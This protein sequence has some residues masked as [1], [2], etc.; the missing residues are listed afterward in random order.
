MKIRYVSIAK[1]IA[2]LAAAIVPLFTRAASG[3]LARTANAPKIFGVSSSDEVQKGD[4][5]IFTNAASE[6]SLLL[7]RAIKADILV[8]GGGGAGANPGA[9]SALQ[10]GAGG[11]GAGGM[12]ETNAYFASGTYYVVV[13]GGGISPEGQGVGGNGEP[14]K[15]LLDGAA[16]YEAFGGGGGG[17]LGAGADGGSGGGGSMA[18]GGLGALGQGFG[19]GKSIYDRAGGGGGGAGSVG[20]VT[21]AVGV[22]GAGGLGKASTITGAKLYYAAGGGGGSRKGESVAFGGNGIGGNGG[23]AVAKATDGWRNSGSGGGGGSLNTKGGNGGSGI[24]VIKIID[25]LPTRPNIA[26]S[27]NYNGENQVVY[28]GSNGVIIKKDGDIVS[29]IAVK[30]A[31]TY[32]YTVILKEGYVWADLTTDAEVAVTVAVNKAVETVTVESIKIEPWQIGQ[33]PNKPVV[34]TT[35]FQVN[36]SDYV[37]KYSPKG[38]N[39]W[40]EE[41]PTEPGVYDVT[42]EFRTDSYTVNERIPFI[43]VTLSAFDEAN[44]AYLDSLGYRSKITITEAIE[45]PLEDVVMPIRIREN[46]PSGFK[47]KY[48]N[49]DGSDIRFVDSEGKLIPHSVHIWNTFGESKILV[50]IPEFKKDAVITMCWGEL[51]NKTPP[52]IEDLG[53]IDEE[54]IKEATHVFTQAEIIPGVCFKN[55]WFVE[56]TITKTQWKYGEEAASVTRGEAVYGDWYYIF[57]SRE[58]ITNTVPTEPGA[59]VFRAQVDGLNAIKD[60]S[61]GYESLVSSEKDVLISGIPA[62]GA[63]GGEGADVTLLGRVL[64]ANDWGYG[65]GAVRGQNYFCTNAVA[66]SYWIHGSEGKFILP[67]LSRSTESRLMSVEPID[68]LCGDTTIWRLS[69]VRI[70][71]LYEKDGTFQNIRNY[72][73]LSPEALPNNELTNSVHLALGNTKDAAIYSPMYTNGIGTI[74]FDAVN[75]I[76]SED[77]SGLGFKIVVEVCT[78]LVNDAVSSSDEEADGEVGADVI[79]ELIW[80]PV[81]MQALKKDGASYFEKPFETERLAL[82]IK[83]GGTAENFYRVYVELNYREPI[84]FRIRRDEVLEDA[85]N[86]KVFI[87]V[88]N[89]VAS[90]PSAR[91]DLESYGKCDENKL[92]KQTL[93]FEGAFDVKFP[94]VNNPFYGRG[95][96]KTEL[97]GEAKNKLLD[98]I[99]SSMIFYRWRYLEQAESEW[100]G[101]VLDQKNGFKAVEPFTL[102]KDMP[103][104]VEY[105]YVSRVNAPYYEYIDYTGLDLNLGGYYSEYVPVVTNRL[106][107]P[108]KFESGGT[109]WFVRLREAKS[110]YEKIN[111]IVT[112]TIEDPD[113]WDDTE[114]KTNSLSMQLVGNGIWRGLY[115]T[116]KANPKGVQYRFEAMN[117]QSDGADEWN[118][119]TNYWAVDKSWDKLPVTDVMR[120]ASSNSWS[121]VTN[122]AVTGYLLF[123]IDD[124]RKSITIVHADYQDFNEWTDANKNGSELFV[125]NSIDDKDKSGVSSTTTRSEV[126]FKGWT[127]MPATNNLWREA[128]AT[129]AGLHYKEY[130]SFSESQTPNGWRAL[131]SMFVYSNYKDEKQ[132]EDNAIARAL[133]MEG[134]GLGSVEL[135]SAHTMPRGI[136]TIS[137][138]ARLAQAVDFNDCAYY[139]GDTGSKM[140]NYTFVVAGAF[141]SNSNKDFRGNASLS[142]FA[143]YQPRVGAYELRVEQVLGGSSP[144]AKGVSLTLYRWWRD[145]TGRMTVDLLLAATNSVNTGTTKDIDWPKLNG[146]DGSGYQPIYLSVSNTDDGTKIQAGFMNQASSSVGTGWQIDGITGKTFKNISH[147]DKTANKLEAGTYGLLTANSEGLFANPRIFSE[148][149]TVNSNKVTFNGEPID[150][151]SDITSGNWEILPYRMAKDD[152][153]LGLTAV[154]P[155]QA[156]KIYTK[157]ANKDWTFFTSTNINTFGNSGV[158]EP[159][160]I[161]VYTNTDLAIR[162]GTGGDKYDVRTDIVIDDIEISQ[163]RGGN[164]VDASGSS[165]DYNEAEFKFTTAWIKNEAVLLSARRTTPENPSS[166]YSPFY[167]G[168]DKRGLGLGMFS[169]KYKDVSNTNVVLLLQMATNVTMNSDGYI[170]D[171]FDERTWVTCTN[172]TF[173]AEDLA[174]GQRSYYLGLHGVKGVMRLVMDPKVVEKYKDEMDS[175][176]FPEIYITEVFS[177]DE[178]TLNSSAWWGWN[179]RTLGAVDGRDN[180]KR[181]YLYD[182]TR[183]N[184]NG[185]S[186]ALNNSTNDIVNTNQ[187]ADYEEYEPFLQTPLFERDVVGEITF[188]ARKYDVNNSQPAQVTLYGSRTGASTAEG[189]EPIKTFD[190]YNTIYT[191]FSY[192]TEPGKEYK[193]FRLAV[194]G[195]DVKSPMPVDKDKVKY[196]EPVRVLIDEVLVSE[197]IRAAFA[198]RKVG[199]FRSNL[200][201]LDYVPNVPSAEEQPLTGESWGVQCEIFAAQLEEEIDWSRQPI[202]KLHWFRGVDPWGYNNWKDLPGAESAELAAVENTNLI[203][204]SSMRKVQEGN[205]VIPASTKTP[206]TVQYELELI[207]YTKESDNPLTNYLSNVGMWENPSWYKGYDLNAGRK[208]YVAYTILDN[209]SPGW[210]WINE[211]NVLGGYD[212]NGINKDLDYQYVEVAA[213]ANAKLEGWSVRMIEKLTEKLL[214]TNTVAVFGE[215][216]LASLKVKN[217]KDNMVF[218]VIG[219]PKSKESGKLKK[220]NGTLDGVWSFTNK[221]DVMNTT[222]GVI[223]PVF[224]IGVQLVRKSGIVEHEVGFIGENLFGPD[225][226]LYGEYNASNFV[227]QVNKLIGSSFIYVGADD[228]D[229]N[230]SLSVITNRGEA[231]SY[232]VNNVRC[233][234]GEINDTQKI[235]GLPPTSN[236]SSILVYAN[237]NTSIPRIR[238]SFGGVPYTDT[239]LIF[240]VPKELSE[241]TNISYKVDKWH[242]LKSVTVNGIALPIEGLKPERDALGAAIY[243]V[244]IAENAK[245]NI[246]IEA[247]AKLSDDLV[248]KYG[249]GPDNKYRDAVIDWLEKGES[250]VFGPW[251]KPNSD[252]IYLAEY[253]SL[254]GVKIAE[255]TLTQMY[256]LDID[257]TASNFVF[258]GGMAKAPEPKMRSL[259]IGDE[260]NDYIETT[261]YKMGVKL[262]ITNKTENASSKY[263]NKAW[264]PYVLRGRGKGET[265][266]D[267]SAATQPWSNVTFKVTGFLNN[268]LTELANKNNWIP[269]RWFVFDGWDDENGKSRSFNDE[270]T[271]YIEISDPFSKQSPGYNAGWYDW[272]LVNPND[273][274]FFS[275]SIDTRLNMFP[276]EI[277]KSENYYEYE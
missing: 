249:L 62:G 232:W 53:L 120:E 84:R 35:P 110:D 273:G 200:D 24:V 77:G 12:I 96:L 140:T 43:D 28:R 223:L 133:Q 265:S 91:I 260:S 97:E 3:E 34:K 240:S 98:Y 137:F 188:K 171:R 245:N 238:Q 27:V 237:L 198:F 92:G 124:T 241:G 81:K 16:L 168:D 185:M 164:W 44:K 135:T 202:V 268:G 210:A 118:V 67:Y 79:N 66:G 256:W 189:W 177:R 41:A 51:V 254:S 211:A 129:T 275:W 40:S 139:N 196:D 49:S 166:I 277:L 127:D 207:Y 108:I 136:D 132:K 57:A 197:A 149:V 246:N 155:T 134:N 72:L 121:T 100:R 115:K 71:N 220:D 244:T 170:I 94:S 87:L 173:T 50:K 248:E 192:K 65:V 39:E 167:D 61:F 272:H 236:G 148:P 56:P 75:S 276:V 54:N 85:E 141:D 231:T 125:G 48:A 255:M 261:N 52:S 158:Q 59:Y 116:L 29:E 160:E 111:L 80:M 194:T 152:A 242:E 18:D 186:L 157:E 222:T 122:D 1:M 117:R 274:L 146:K 205:A 247:S 201:T 182:K 251:E 63:L 78:N 172:F 190:I 5:L 270:F 104:D 138:K 156:V 103:G 107:S 17:F 215:R 162:L 88:D 126:D 180:E 221:G 68:D 37:V 225:D 165:E 187:A 174:E 106:D 217:M 73:P 224:P 266:L 112:E 153:I 169:F 183:D 38:L 55:R 8:V 150:C 83:N 264:A 159:I 252:E 33:T 269:L 233:T 64:L 4:V 21:A 89:I 193:A 119:S 105:Y 82:N 253:Q 144:T 257:P 206:E 7:S 243:K 234:P 60:G 22:G 176:K 230:Y 47:Y 23:S 208:D 14:T 46:V 263:Y 32:N 11:G 13:G 2:A 259:P 143:Y 212:N 216:D 26:Y 175:E 195:V 128:F 30:D 6:V 258:R 235:V 131:N 191:N 228:K 218:H 95:K 93:G 123:Q 213:P 239:S 161:N 250:L 209:V 36:S 42:I 113:G 15:I 10:G 262:Y 154:K 151:Y 179:L 181:M 86:D 101:I 76:V 271:T 25:F 19:G 163:F 99:T 102:P 142:L 31:G 229:G 145:E 214:V 199:A 178:P 130:E 109:N 20:G 90:E 184:P 114:Y 227:N 219:S 226:F 203:Y 9:A 204:R 70:G 147:T 69:N 45:T 74:Y 58:V 267:Y